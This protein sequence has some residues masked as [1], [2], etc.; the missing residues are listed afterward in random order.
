[1]VQR[2]T[3]TDNGGCCD[4]ISD[5]QLEIDAVNQ[6]AIDA[7]TTANTASGRI[8]SLNSAVSDLTES[9]AGFDDKIGKNTSDI[10]S[11]TARLDEDEPTIAS[12]KTRITTAE[13]DISGLKTRMT[14]AESDISLL[15]ATVKTAVKEVTVTQDASTVYHK[16][17]KISGSTE[18]DA[19][20]VASRTQAGVM[21][22]SIYGGFEDQINNNSD[23]ISVLE[24]LGTVYDITGLVGTDP[25]TSEITAAFNSKYPGVTIIAGMR[26]SDY[27]NAHLWQFGNNEWI[28]LT[29]VVI[30]TA[31]NTSLGTV[32]GNESTAGKVYVES[33]GSM[34]LNGYDA[35]VSK[36]SSQDGKITALESWRTTAT[37]QIA[38]L[39]ADLTTAEGDIDTLESSVAG[40]ASDV[41]TLSG[42]VTTNTSNIS[43]LTSKVNSNTSNISS[44]Q[45]TKQDK[46]IA[47][48]NI[49]I[50]SDGKTISASGK[51]YT[52]GSGITISSS[53]VIST[54]VPTSQTISSPISI[55]SGYISGSANIS[56]ATTTLQKVS[57]STGQVTSNLYS[58]P[59]TSTSVSNKG[60]YKVPS[61]TYVYAYR[62]KV[63][64]LFPEDV[65]LNISC[66]VLDDRNYLITSGSITLPAG[67]TSAYLKTPLIDYFSQSSTIP[68]TIY[69]TTITIIE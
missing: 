61:N 2:K 23:R 69:A 21:S 29:Q 50:A 16:A 26:V 46:L 7:K 47:G 17:I 66:I 56:T 65:S 67:D 54:T 20:P 12:N 36:D 62:S 24:S 37:S 42:K 52:A 60:I 59:Y 55:G 41:S 45:T 19:L 33:D 28:I 13:G 68:Y 48:T 11:L 18:I 57:F 39:D 25:T 35:L 38:S 34:S 27:D 58:I 1:M 14:D 53:G 6:T 32:K 64:N 4:R 51:E 63:G 3:T 8:D 31:T 9:V 49:T 5:L 43:T 40:V 15:D 22:A 10:T 44:M 30:A